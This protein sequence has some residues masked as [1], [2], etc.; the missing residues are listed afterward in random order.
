MLRDPGYNQGKRPGDATSLNHRKRIMV[1]E[2]SPWLCYRCFRQ[3]IISPPCMPTAVP[4]LRSRNKRCKKIHRPPD[5]A[6]WVETAINQTGNDTV[7]NK[8]R[9][10]QGLNSSAETK[11]KQ[12]QR[13]KI[14]SNEVL[15]KYRYSDA[16]AKP[17][18][19][20]S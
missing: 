1:R 20:K 5:V 3:S 4:K 15:E 6:A 9:V 2:Y 8:H 10:T 18:Q 11:G 19:S 7:R 14:R 13:K 16:Q 12:R 17:K